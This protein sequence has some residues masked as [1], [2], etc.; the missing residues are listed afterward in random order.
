MAVFSRRNARCAE[1]GRIPF[2]ESG[3]GKNPFPL[4][5]ETAGGLFLVPAEAKSRTRK[6]AVLEGM[7]DDNGISLAF[8]F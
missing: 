1:D 7:D 2:P 4:G 6:R 8:L 5:Y 3:G